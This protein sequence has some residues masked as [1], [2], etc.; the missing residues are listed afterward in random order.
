M[1]SFSASSFP[2]IEFSTM[3]LSRLC[4]CKA[5]LKWEL[6]KTISKDEL[7]PDKSGCLVAEFGVSVIFDHQGPL[8]RTFGD[9]PDGSLH[10]NALKIINLVRRTKL[11]DRQ[12][13]T[14]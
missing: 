9:V 14:F 7:I 11:T 4:N 5:S 8:D 10:S 3:Y 12:H 1:R 2:F 6:H 13:C